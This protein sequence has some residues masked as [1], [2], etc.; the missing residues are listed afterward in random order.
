MSEDQ[1]IDNKKVETA[2]VVVK[3]LDG[4]FTAYT[5]VDL[6]IEQDRIALPNDIK[7]AAHALYEALV[8]EEAIQAAVGRFLAH[9]AKVEAEE[10]KPSE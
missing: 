9:Q 10:V 1:I 4:S 6:G 8:K 7:H 5:E 3:S 2:F